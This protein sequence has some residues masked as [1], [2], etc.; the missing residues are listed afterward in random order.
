MTGSGNLAAANP[1]A[2]SEMMYFETGKPS[3]RDHQGAATL[4]NARKDYRIF[5]NAV[6]STF[7]YKIKAE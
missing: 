7:S 1:T 3:R 4:S 5:E 2:F 6:T